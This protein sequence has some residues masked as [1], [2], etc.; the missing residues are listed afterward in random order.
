MAI[1]CPK[2]GKEFDVTLFQFGNTVRCDCGACV[3]ISVGHVQDAKS[4][5]ENQASDPDAPSARVASAGNGIGTKSLSQ[6]QKT[7]IPNP[8]PE[9][10]GGGF[11]IGSTCGEK[12]NS[13]PALDMTNDSEN[14]DR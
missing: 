7:P 2:C 13:G 6:D 12:E 14:N 3:D 4:L 9:D 5:A 10:G 11:G 8:S 1:T